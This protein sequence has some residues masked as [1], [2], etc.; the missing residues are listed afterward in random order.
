MLNIRKLREERGLSQKEMVELSGIA[1]GTISAYEKEYRTIMNPKIEYMEILAKILD[2]TLSEMLTGH[3]DNLEGMACLNQACLLNENK[4]CGSRPVRTGEAV[5]Y[6]KD[7][8]KDKLVY[9]SGWA[10]LAGRWE[11]YR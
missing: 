11:D 10:G 5:C 9:K 6:G 3:K 2:V 8:V 7:L 1:Q 4:K